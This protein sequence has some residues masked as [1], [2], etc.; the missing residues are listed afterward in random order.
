MKMLTLIEDDSFLVSGDSVIGILP[1]NQGSQSADLGT[2][3]EICQSIVPTKKLVR[4]ACLKSRAQ[5]IELYSSQMLDNAPL[6][7]SVL[8]S[9]LREVIVDDKVSITQMKKEVKKAQKSDKIIHVQADVDTIKIPQGMSRADQV[10][11]LFAE[12]QTSPSKI[13]KVIGAHPSYVSTI[14]KK[15][16]K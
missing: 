12:G 15:L 11:Q 9:K 13:A 2:Y 7:I 16:R 3:P 10:K 14:L 5:F 4:D 8:Y 1:A 6:T